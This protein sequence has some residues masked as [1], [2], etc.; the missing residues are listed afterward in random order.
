M[1]TM[2]DNI[3]FL[4]CYRQILNQDLLMS[5]RLHGVRMLS[6]RLFGTSSATDLKC[7]ILPRV[8]PDKTAMLDRTWYNIVY[9]LQTV[10]NPSWDNKTS[11][12]SD[13]FH[14]SNTARKTLCPVEQGAW[15]RAGVTESSDATEEAL[16]LATINMARYNK[17]LEENK[18]VPE[19]KPVS[20]DGPEHEEKSQLLQLT[21][22]PCV[23]CGKHD[24]VEN[25]VQCPGY[26]S[27]QISHFLWSHVRCGNPFVEGATLKGI[28]VVGN[29]THSRLPRGT[30]RYLDGIAIQDTELLTYLCR[31]NHL[32]RSDRQRRKQSSQKCGRAAA[33]SKLGP[34]AVPRHMR[35]LPAYNT[36]SRTQT[37]DRYL[38]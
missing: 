14:F 24:H 26:F 30:S 25:I 4:R 31:V 21:P 23:T 8:H 33:V 10:L 2:V 37:N 7:K 19:T 29:R 36:R 5:A 6:E 32:K 22:S 9:A 18:P 34:I 17:A 38:D 16:R 27:R 3:E 15:S 1:A 12:L 28:Y 35:N 13:V 11:D 20:T